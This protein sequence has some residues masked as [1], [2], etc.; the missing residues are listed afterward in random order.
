ME[1]KEQPRSLDFIL[2]AFVDNTYF[3]HVFFRLYFPCEFEEPPAHLLSPPEEEQGWW[4]CTV[5]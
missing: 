1:K 3:K 5:S 4:A 2:L